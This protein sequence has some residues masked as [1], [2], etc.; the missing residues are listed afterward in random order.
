MIQLVLA[1]L[2]LLLLP[3]VSAAA[4]CAF[5]DLNDN[6]VFDGGDILTPDAAW[7]GG[8][9]FTT[10][11]PW[12]V[13]VG[14]EKTLIGAPPAVV[15]G[16]RVTA[17]KISFFGKLD[18]F[19]NGGRG[20]VFLATGDFTMGDGINPAH[21]RAGGINA[22]PA[23]TIALAHRSIALG[24]GGDCLFRFADLITSAPAAN[25]QVGIRCDGDLTFRNSSVIGSRVNIQS[26]F[27]KIDASNGAGPPGGLLQLGALCDDPVTNLTANGNGNG[28]IDAGDFPC[29]L[30]LGGV[31]NFADLP[32][33]QAACSPFAFTPGN[34]F[35]A[36][37]DP[38]I[39]IAGAGGPENT[40]D[41]RFASLVG[42]YRVTLAA[43]DG[44]I[45]TQNAAIDNGQ[46]LGIS[47]PGGARVWVFA[48]PTTVIRLPV[49]LEDFLGP[50]AA[51]T[52]IQDACYR[53]KNPINVGRDAANALNLVG[54]PA[55]APCAQNPPDFV[56]VL[57][58]IF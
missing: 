34:V 17:A 6:Q 13:P 38:L 36:F 46:Q 27:G 52:F 31:V 54:T 4:D 20:V 21:I 53:S 24:G 33:L 11:N 18:Y 55:P 1:V 47:P 3:H 51:Q 2:M 57:N 44:A 43:E 22:L 8:A 25:T 40:L 16:V 32:A 19:P 58:G 10:L 39:F 26:L 56:K 29:Q 9:A 5:E 23:N 7:L 45:L 30:N 12:V 41:L 15:N 48:D 28:L 37:N 42:L 49:D 50:S 14:C 35:R